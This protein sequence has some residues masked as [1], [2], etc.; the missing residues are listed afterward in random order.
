MIIWRLKSVAT[1]NPEMRAGSD[2]TR[3][4]ES[5]ENPLVNELLLRWPSGIIRLHPQIRSTRGRCVHIVRR[6]LSVLS[7]RV[8][9]EAPPE[10]R[11]F[12]FGWPLLCVAFICLGIGVG[13]YRTPRA[14]PVGGHLSPSPSLPAGLVAAQSL[15][16]LVTAPVLVPEAPPAS[17]DPTTDDGTIPESET[18]RV[19]LA[20]YTVRPGDTLT[21][22]AE[23][24]RTSTA[25]IVQINGLSS[26]DLLSVGMKLSVMENASGVVVKVAQGDTLWDISRRYGVSIAEIAH[27]NNLD[28]TQ[29]LPVGTTLLL[30]GA[31]ARSVPVVSRSSSFRW[32]IQGSLTSSYGW[33]T[34]PI[35]GQ[36][37]FH[38]GLDIAA[39]S[40][41]AIGA[42]LGGTVKYAG[43]LG[44]YGRLVTIDHGDGLET[45]YAHMSA[46]NVSQGQ[47]VSA[48]NTI[49]YV[50]QSGDATG[51]HVHFEI[52]KNGRTLNPRD[53]LP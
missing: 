32:P 51:P 38:D 1:R 8:K 6:H 3:V 46:I 23:A 14:E 52:R 16:E 7:F 15:G 39:S 34:H 45:R 49:G 13:L 40:G 33:R 48:G 9:S 29:V 28:V 21:A 10:G 4:G 53:Y 19:R 35:T 50:G 42:S 37:S 36:E 2:V 20:T 25:S 11:R 44:G 43:W 41:T 12:R 31:S 18:S 26:P 30:P 27:V 24:F 47:I 5:A 22:I 17:P